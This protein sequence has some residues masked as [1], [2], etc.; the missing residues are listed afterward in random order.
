LTEHLPPRV[1][2]M[3]KV[4]IRNAHTARQPN[5]LP[6]RV[7]SDRFAEFRTEWE[8]L[9]MQQMVHYCGDG[10][11]ARFT[12]AD[13]PFHEETVKFFTDPHVFSE[14]VRVLSDSLYDFLALEGFLALPLDWHTSQAKT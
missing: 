3:A 13:Q 9:L 12:S 4:T 5:S 6:Y 7:Q 2:Q 1:P 14:T 11:L 10:L 8:R